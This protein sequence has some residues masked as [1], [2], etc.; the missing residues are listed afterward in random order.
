MEQ[1]FPYLRLAGFECDYSW[2]IDEKDDRIFY[3]RGHWLS[4]LGIFMKAVTVRLRDVLRAGKYDVIFVQREAF[5]TGSAF[6]EKQ[7]SRSPAKLIFD[8]DDAIWLE[9]TSVSNRNLKWLKRPAKTTD[10]IKMADT[11]IAGNS[12]LAEYARQFNPRVHVIPTVVDTSIFEPSGQRSS[13][14]VNIGWIGSSTTL[15][16]FNLLIPALKSLK[17]KFGETIS[18]IQISDREISVDGLEIKNYSWNARGELEMIRRFDIG[19]MPL[20]DDV[21]S[22][23]KCGFKAIQ[24][25]AMAVPPVVSPVGVNVEVVQH[26]L[27]GY[28]A[29][30]DEEWTAYISNLVESHELRNRLGKGGRQR[31]IEK[32]SVTAQLP[33]LIAA[34]QS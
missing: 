34:L 28:H 23:G 27:N 5:M 18:I 3:S 20:P 8:F 11:V 32:Y 13:G 10:I 2:F 14:V 33:A 21:W 30:T 9:D 19:L 25:M 31:V 7:F 17:K 4:K 26:G 15:R 24:Y 16:H 6:F 22:K 1:F 12:F 29:V